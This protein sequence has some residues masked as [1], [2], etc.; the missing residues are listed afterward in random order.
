MLGA[1][2]IRPAAAVAAGLDLF[3]A[4][5]G[6]WL[7]GGDLPV[8][9]VL[10]DTPRGGTV[11]LWAARCSAAVGVLLLARESA[12]MRQTPLANG[13]LYVAALIIC[14]SALLALCCMG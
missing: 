4:T 5:L 7:L 13:C 10:L 1:Y 8:V 9:G 6:Y 3:E 14:G 12:R 11:T 2:D